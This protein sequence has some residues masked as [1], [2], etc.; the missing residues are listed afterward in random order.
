MGE[1]GAR[2]IDVGEESWRRRLIGQLADDGVAVL[3]GVSDRRRVVAVASQVMELRAHPDAGTDMVTVIEDRGL[4]HRPGLAGFGDTEMYPHTEGTAVPDPPTVLMLACARQASTGGA[5]L[6]VDAAV[7]HAELKAQDPDFVGWLTRPETAVFGGGA[8][9][10]GRVFTPAADGR[11]LV[12]WRGDGLV[13]FHPRIRERLPL[14]RAAI[15]RNTIGVALAVG[16]ALVLSNTW[17]LHARTAFTGPRRMWRI[18]GDLHPEH[19]IPLGFRPRPA[20]CP[21]VGQAK[22]RSQPGSAPMIAVT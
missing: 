20:S 16:E 8:G 9:F 17:W 15:D 10:R 5:S 4:T 2:R 12:R 22:P 18:L 21:H 6:L 14:L 7:V 3:G 11:V 19:G 1:I 13:G